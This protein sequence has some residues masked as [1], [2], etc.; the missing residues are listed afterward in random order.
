MTFIPNH[1]DSAKKSKQ[2]NRKHN[3]SKEATWT[4]ENFWDSWLDEMLKIIKIQYNPWEQEKKQ[5]INQLGKNNRYRWLILTTSTEGGKR[6]ITQKER[7]QKYVTS[8]A[9]KDFK[10]M[11]PVKIRSILAC[12]WY[13]TSLLYFVLV[14]VSIA[15]HHL[16]CPPGPGRHTKSFELES[17]CTLGHLSPIV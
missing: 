11:V 12:A 3:D 6:R 10:L 8:R 5:W 17:L 13:T 16:I 9:T 2:R 7:K 4:I 1:P 14:D 15:L